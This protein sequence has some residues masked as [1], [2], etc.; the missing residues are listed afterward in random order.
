MTLRTDADDAYVAALAEVVNQK[1]GEV[2]A[3]SRTLSTHVLAVMAALQL[4]DD[5]IQARKRETELRRKVK[6]K[7]QKILALLE[8]AT[9][10]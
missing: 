5:L 8:G 6:E 1:I 4:A 3:S 10:N 9:D 2:K 7:S